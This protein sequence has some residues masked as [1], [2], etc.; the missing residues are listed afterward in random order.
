MR[1][2]LLSTGLRLGGAERQVAE[3][4]RAFLALGHKVA[5]VSLTPQQ[6]VELPEGVD[7]LRLSLRQT[8][9]SFLATLLQVRRW[10]A[11]WRPDIVHAHMFH[12]NIFARLLKPRGLSRRIVPVVCTA[13]SLRE[14]GKLRMLAY[15]MTDRR[16]ALTT[17]VSEA[18]RQHLISTGA[19]PAERVRVMPNGID[20]SRFRPDDAERAATRQRLGIP[21]ATRVILNVGRLV[22]EK[23]QNRLVDAF[24]LLIS[25]GNNETTP[26]L[27]IAGDG[28]QRD[29]LQ[30]QITQRGLAARVRLLGPRHDIPALLNAAD[31]FVLSSDLE[32]LPLVVGEAMACGTPVVAT[33]V[34]GIRALFR[35][36]S[37]IVPVGDTEA[38]AQ[39]MQ[40][41]LSKPRA[42]PEVIANRALIL[43][44]FDLNVVANRWLHIYA[45]LAVDQP[46][47]SPDS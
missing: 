27:W 5:V 28:P 31:L 15:R 14:G 1:I 8:P 23:A 37:G 40:R 11:T 34:P 9:F 4:A 16:C 26:I 7:V 20:T 25:K 43:E 29:A 21:V 35:H 46:S 38:M 22:A 2:A 42:D 17:H 12:A 39:A 32:G 36:T 30:K 33:D 45:R 18:G 6:E 47:V 19:A 41:Y 24:A 10:A 13:H 3:L 44:V